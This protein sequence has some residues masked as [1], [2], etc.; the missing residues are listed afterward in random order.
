MAT[1]VD[2][3]S[4]FGRSLERFGKLVHDVP[5]DGWGSPTPCTEWDVRALV[6]HLVGRP[7]REQMSIG[8]ARLCAACVAACALL[9]GSVGFEDFTPQ[10][11]RDPRTQALARR[12]AVEVQDL[13][14]ANALTPV[15]VEIRLRDGVRHTTRLDVVY[16]NPAKPLSRDDHL[17]KFRRNCAAAA[18][19]LQPGMA[20]RL[21]D[22][23]DRLEDV[24]DVAELVDLAAG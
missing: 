23:I 12:I 2:V 9:R 18:T 17:D 13:G 11:Y 6:H 4:L 19:P 5:A 14:D 20:E 7:P 21:I 1:D 24:A 16:G 10:A 8:Y 22:R 3:P 15:E